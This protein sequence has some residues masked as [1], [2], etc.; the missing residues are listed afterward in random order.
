[1]PTINESADACQFRMGSG[2]VKLRHLSSDYKKELISPLGLFLPPWLFL[3]PSY[4]FCL[5]SHF[6]VGLVAN[7]NQ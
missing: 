2:K 1:M 4:C 3:P 6:A 7:P 5:L